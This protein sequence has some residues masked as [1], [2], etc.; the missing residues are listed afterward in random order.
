MNKTYW[1]WYWGVDQKDLTRHSKPKKFTDFHRMKK[2]SANHSKNHQWIG[3]G[4]WSSYEKV[5]K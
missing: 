4:Y 3:E 2:Y 1:I 5:E